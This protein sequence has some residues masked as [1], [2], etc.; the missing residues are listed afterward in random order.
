LAVPENRNAFDVSRAENLT[1]T[2]LQDVLIFPPPGY[3][4]ANC[5]C[6]FLKIIPVLRECFAISDLPVFPFRHS[7]AARSALLPWLTP[8]PL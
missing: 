8:Q 4:L 3:L 7:Y 5:S 2:A 1:G 6:V